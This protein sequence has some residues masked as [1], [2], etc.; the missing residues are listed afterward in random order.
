[1]C[2]SSCA[3]CMD[4]DTGDLGENFSVFTSVNSLDERI[5]GTLRKVSRQDQD[6]QECCSA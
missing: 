4:D 5:K 1:M 2:T 3:Q 6:E